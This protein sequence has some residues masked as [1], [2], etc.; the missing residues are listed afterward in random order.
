[1]LIIK[2]ERIAP[3]PVML[4]CSC[5]S[6]AGASGGH[7]FL[8]KEASSANDLRR[9][10]GERERDE[11][12]KITER[13]FCFCS[14][15]PSSR[16]NLLLLLIYGERL[17]FHFLPS[18][19]WSF[20]LLNAFVVLVSAMETALMFL[21]MTDFASSC[22]TCSCF[23]LPTSF[24]FKMPLLTS[25]GCDRAEASSQKCLRTVKEVESLRSRA[26]FL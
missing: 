5:V 26:R 10:G 8:C 6:G 21:Q 18:L 17:V 13:M 22:S 1:M 19:S 23:P 12:A 24:K 11:E 3:A 25:L 15:A 2:A 14:V 20:A 4:E 9:F 16:T 7:G